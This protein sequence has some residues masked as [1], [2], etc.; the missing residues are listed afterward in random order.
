MQY[1][2]NL[3]IKE[4]KGIRLWQHAGAS[5]PGSCFSIM[6]TGKIE[7][8]L[9]KGVPSEDRVL[10]VQVGA[11]PEGDEAVRKISSIKISTVT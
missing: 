9:I 11:G 7:D 4:R 3:F 1:E 6:N 5:F 8:K 10:S 2:G